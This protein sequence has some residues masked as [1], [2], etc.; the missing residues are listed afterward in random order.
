[1]NTISMIGWKNGDINENQFAIAKVSMRGT[2]MAMVSAKSM[3]TPWRDFGHCYA[4][5]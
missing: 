2:T 4:H 5:G 1:M 3:S